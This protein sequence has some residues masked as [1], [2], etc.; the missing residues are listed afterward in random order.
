[1]EPVAPSIESDFILGQIY[2]VLVA[3]FAIRIY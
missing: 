3:M 1:M 2:Y